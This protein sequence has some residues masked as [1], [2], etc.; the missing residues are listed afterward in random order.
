[1]TTVTPLTYKPV[2]INNHSPCNINRFQS[3]SEGTIRKIFMS[4]KITEFHN[5]Q[6][7][8]RRWKRIAESLL[9]YSLFKII[10]LL[11]KQNISEF[12]QCISKSL[13]AHSVRLKS[14]DTNC[15]YN[16]FPLILM[17]SGQE[18]VKRITEI[19]YDNH[20]VSIAVKLD[21]QVQL[22][23][24]IDNLFSGPLLVIKNGKSSTKNDQT[25]ENSAFSSLVTRFVKHLNSPVKNSKYKAGGDKEKYNRKP[26]D[27]VNFLL[28]NLKYDFNEFT[29]KSLEEEIDNN[30]PK[31][32]QGN[33][34]IYFV[35]ITWPNPYKDKP[36]LYK[37]VFYHCFAI[38]Q[39]YSPYKKKGCFRVHNSNM[40][41]MSIKQ[42]YHQRKY[43]AFS[44]HGCLNRKG[45]TNFFIDFN[46]ILKGEHGTNDSISLRC[47]GTRLAH[48]SPTFYDENTRT[49]HGLSLRYHSQLFKPMEC[50][51]N[52][53]TFMNDHKTDLPFIRLDE[54]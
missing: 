19:L 46:L 42:F 24:E 10:D 45:L 52:I 6:L 48:L 33:S 50:V 27:E 13:I 21:S 44:D 18:H 12:I 7:V 34:A 9:P 40:K 37:Y 23:I 47:F 31:I 35:A 22:N 54:L 39:L 30:T 38:E 53:V 17:A 2:N 36:Q 32:D 14:L 15:Y 25:N 4:L 3:L 16:M 51:K 1:M 5:L 41:E 8:N 20:N 49:L 26:L 29:L 11:T 28:N 43:K